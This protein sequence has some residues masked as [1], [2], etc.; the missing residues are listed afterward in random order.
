MHHGPRL[1][2]FRTSASHA[3]S[4]RFFVPGAGKNAKPRRLHSSPVDR[5]TGVICDQAVRPA[6]HRAS[7][8]HPDHMRRVKCRDGDRGKHSRSE[9]AALLCRPRHCGTAS[10]AMAGRVVLQVDRAA[11]SNEVFSGNVRQCGQDAN[12]DLDHRLCACGHHRETLELRAESP[13]NS[14]SFG[15]DGI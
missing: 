11:S 1:S 4:W 3:P 15:R 14:A 8:E 2:R 9:P 7:I 12:L 6:G 13:R 5:G 10:G